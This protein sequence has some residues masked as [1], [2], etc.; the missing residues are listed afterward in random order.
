M[1][2]RVNIPLNT[3]RT[4]A[5][6]LV[7]ISHLRAL[8]FVDF[9]DA[10][11]KSI[12]V[13]AFYLAG[14]LGHPAVIVFFVLSG[15]WVGGAAV[16]SVTSGS[17]TWFKYG[18]ARLTRLWLV[19]IPAVLLTQ[20]LD[21]IGA[22]LN[23]GSSIYAGF[24]GYHT[25][26]PAE[27]P[28]TTLGPMETL[29]NIFFV[30]SIHVPT[31]GTNSP[32]WSLAF[33]FWYYVLFPA[34][35]VAMSGKF[36]RKVRH[37]SALL[38]VA[39]AVT[40]GPG[41]LALFPAWLIGAA[42]AW[43]QEQISGIIDRLSHTALLLARAAA[44]LAV[45][46]SSCAVVAFGDRMPGLGIVVAAPSALMLA[47]LCTR[48]PRAV[49]LRPMSSA[50]EWS[51]SLYAVHV[52]ILAF[53]A[54]FIVPRASDRWQLSPGSA[55]MALLVLGAV[56][57]ASYAMSLITERHTAAL[58]GRILSLRRDSKPKPSTAYVRP[59]K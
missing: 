45:L 36:T 54:S 59:Q 7:V 49:V 48:T 31:L 18:T 39:G 50:A 20:L 53:I 32:L 52:P 13:Q 42:I 33:E 27:G 9:S 37:I 25:V 28:L 3:V 29:G 34:A 12:I 35:L 40:A 43:K 47:L 26:V 23:G 22:G 57:A 21:R 5:A 30:Q 51:Y 1:R 6:F 16:R 41:V 44:V 46:G 15:Y 56:A 2:Q 17:F 14:S 38:A 19:L 58:R 8:F 55:L 10:E 11:S 4:V 24:S